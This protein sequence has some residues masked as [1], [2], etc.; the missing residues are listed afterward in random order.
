MTNHVKKLCNNIWQLLIES[1][2]NTHPKNRSFH[3]PISRYG[4]IL[5][6]PSISSDFEIKST[7]ILRRPRSMRR[8]PAFCNPGFGQF[9]GITI[10]IGHIWAWHH[11]SAE[12]SWTPKTWE[13]LAHSKSKL[14]KSIWKHQGP[15]QPHQG[16]TLTCNPVN[17][18]KNP[19][20]NTTCVYFW[21]FLNCF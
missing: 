1:F 19:Y 12:G 13:R 5:S 6:F 21:I 17:F 15:H 16:P 9:S 7:L 14:T 10:T 4:K 8:A 20:Y 3:T 2:T 11:G 18:T